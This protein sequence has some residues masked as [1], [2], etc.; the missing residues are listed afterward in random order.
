MRY[1]YFTKIRETLTI[2]ET[3]LMTDKVQQV[4]TR[5]PIVVPYSYDPYLRRTAGVYE[6]ETSTSPSHAFAMSQRKT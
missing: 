3:G 2:C 5:H 6:L 1:P 4:R